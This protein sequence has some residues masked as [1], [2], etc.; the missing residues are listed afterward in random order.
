M[1]IAD[2]TLWYGKVLS[3]N[4]EDTQGVR[5]F[6]EF[7]FSREDFQTTL[8]PLRDGVLVAVKR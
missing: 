2:N 7:M 3:E 8:I 4:D 6:N 1:V 5:A